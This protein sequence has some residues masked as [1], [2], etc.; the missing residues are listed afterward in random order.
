MRDSQN[1]NLTQ[2]PLLQEQL[3]SDF[4]PQPGAKGHYF[5][6][7]NYPSA[8]RNFTLPQFPQTRGWLSRQRSF[9]PSLVT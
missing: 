4:Q 2:R 3:P 7:Q 6:I 8:F 9:L 5:K 1:F